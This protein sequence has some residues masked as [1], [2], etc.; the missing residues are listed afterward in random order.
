[1]EDPLLWLLS[2]SSFVEY[3]TRLDLLDQSETEPSV[4]TARKSM[5]TLPFDFQF[6]L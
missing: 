3:R 6:D 5:L 2:S 1:M 4:I